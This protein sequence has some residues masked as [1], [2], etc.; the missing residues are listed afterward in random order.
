[1]ESLAALTDRAALDD[2]VCYGLTAQ[3]A[4]GYPLPPVTEEGD[5]AAELV[6]RARLQPD[7]LTVRVVVRVRTPDA[8]LQVDI[9]AVYSILDILDDSPQALVRF[10]TDSA[11]PTIYPFV[12]ELIAD[13]S[14][15]VGVEHVI[16]S[17]EPPRVSEEILNRLADDLA[18]A[19]QEAIAEARSATPIDRTVPKPPMAARTSRRSARKTRGT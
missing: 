14:R 1:L 16:A 4:A 3:S 9:G 6:I 2:I 17:L 11:I 19:Q 12:R 8:A 7:E 10:I 5:A 15:R 18:R 13:T